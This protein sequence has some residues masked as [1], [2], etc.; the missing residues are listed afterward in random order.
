[1]MSC[2]YEIVDILE[3]RKNTGNLDD[4]YR[5][6]LACDG[7]GMGGGTGLAEAQP[8]QEVGYLGL[9]NVVGGLSA[10]GCNAAYIKTGQ[11]EEGLDVYRTGLPSD[12]FVSWKRFGRDVV[13]MSVLDRAMREVAPLDVDALVESPTPL[14]I[15]VTNLTDYEPVAV[16]IGA[17]SDVEA[18]EVIPWLERGGH[19]PFVAGPPPVDRE[20]T[21][22]ADGGLSWASTEDMLAGC[23]HIMTLSCK[24]FRGWKDSPLSVR[25]V[26]RWLSRHNPSAG[27]AY[28]RMV[29]G[30]TSRLKDRT[31][32]QTIEAGQK[33]YRIH[34]EAVKG[35]PGLLTSDPGRINL[36]IEAGMAAMARFID[37]T[38][39]EVGHEVVEEIVDVPQQI[40][41]PKVA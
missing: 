25:P 30:R 18:E 21:A 36:G 37:K 40:L 38:A 3:A 19:L 8:L 9:F 1:M 5:L 12:N 10:G 34:P 22:W 16:E 20:G 35:L 39:H 17:G 29:A 4:G 23:T 27:H 14:R 33:L 7:G 26:A 24:S 28:K 41:A 31:P 32:L 11:I 13:R 6:G 15:A 2:D